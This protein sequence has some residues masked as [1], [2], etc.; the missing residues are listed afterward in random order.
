[1][2]KSQSVRLG[3]AAL[4]LAVFP[5]VPALGQS[6]TEQAKTEQAR[7]DEI[8]KQAAQQFAAGRAVEGQTKDTQPITAAGPK[9]ELTLDDAVAR[10]LERNI[11]ISVQR[12]NPELQ[13]LNIAR[14]RNSYKPTANSTFFQRSQVQPPTSQLNG[15]TIVTNATSTYNAGV[16]QTLPWGGGNYNVAWNNQKLDTN[17]AFANFNPTFNSNL[18][19]TVTQPLLKSFIIDTNRQQLKVTLLNRDISEV[20]LKGTIAATLAAVRNAYWELLYATQALDVAQQSLDLA[21]KLVADNQARV[22]VGTMARLDVVQSQAEAASRQQALVQAQGVL[23]TTELAL[24]RLIVNGTDDP[25]WHATLV[26]VDRPTFSPAPLDIEG[27]VRTALQ[28]RSDLEAARKTMQGNDITLKFLRNQTLPEVDLIGQYQSQGLGGTQFIRSGTGLG[29]RVIDTIPGGYSDA[30]STLFNRAYPIWQAQVNITYP[31]GGSQADANYARGK[32][33]RSQA[34][35]QMRSIELQVA[36][37]VTNAA[38]QV[39]T[40]LDSYKAAQAARDLAEQ[41]LQAEQSR[42]DVGLSTNFQVVQ[43]Q[44]DLATAQNTELRALLDYRRSQVAYELV[45]QAPSTGT[46]TGV[47]VVSPVATVTGAAGAVAP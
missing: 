18:I 11:D 5:A 34:E 20:Q 3:L 27:A 36:T 7:I 24:K 4:V 28:T 23:R 22:E 9:V 44:R 25:M 29:S 37:D 40:N 12:L 31:L 16:S 13:D 26:P 17:N 2:K 1:M 30:L 19:A 38:L 42:F 14:L 15:G 32:V 10:A 21:N 39:Q 43:A 8:V 6:K 35:A 45:Q 46:G 47:T 41:R 33:Q